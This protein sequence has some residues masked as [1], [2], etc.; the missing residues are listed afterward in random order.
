[1]A[2]RGPAWVVAGKV[3]L[4]IGA[5]APLGNLLWDATHGGL[6]AEPVKDIQHRTGRAALIL[7]LVALAITPL[8]RLSGINPIIRFRRPAG[9]FAFFYAALHFGSYL[10]FDLQFDLM[11]LGEDVVKRPWITIGFA[12]FLIFL[13]LAATSPRAMV[14]RLGG[15]RWQ[16]LHRL[17]YLA[18]IGTVAHFLLAQKKD[19]SD[20]LAYG[21]VLALLLAARL[22]PAP[23]RE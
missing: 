16:R 23:R 13:A 10:L 5:L 22:L 17:V 9:L 21:A 3:L 8:R 12:V 11:A 15:R 20:P 7:L 18:A 14:R 6:L 1:M 4:W 2:G 19:I